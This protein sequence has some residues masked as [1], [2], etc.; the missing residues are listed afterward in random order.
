MVLILVVTVEVRGSRHFSIRITIGVSIEL[1]EIQIYM[2]ML[3]Y[4]QQVLIGASKDLRLTA[5]RYQAGRRLAQCGGC[6]D[7]LLSLLSLRCVFWPPPSTGQ[8]SCPTQLLPH[9]QVIPRLASAA[10]AAARKQT[11]TLQGFSTR[12]VSRQASLGYLG[13]PRGH[14]IDLSTIPCLMGW[15]PRLLQPFWSLIFSSSETI[16]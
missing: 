12:T 15:P 14:P 5:T 11:M 4:I 6:A 1:A 13:L 2:F 8:F 3:V 9:P 10:P 16:R 7:L